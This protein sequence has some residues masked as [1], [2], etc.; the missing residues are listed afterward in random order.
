[1]QA[2]FCGVCNLPKGLTF[3]LQPISGVKSRRGV[4]RSPDPAT[5]GL[6]DTRAVCATCNP[7]RQTM[8][9]RFAADEVFGAKAKAGP[10]FV[11]RD[12][13]NAVKTSFEQGLPPAIAR[14]VGL[15]RA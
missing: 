10:R 7:L 13:S 14:K 11:N 1:M 8:L 5:D 4:C 15:Q 9:P 6:T 3:A 12:L 2:R